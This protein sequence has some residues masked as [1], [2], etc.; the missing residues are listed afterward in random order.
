[1]KRMVQNLV[2]VVV[3]ML[4]LCA[5]LRTEVIL[6]FSPKHIGMFLLGCILLCIPYLRKKTKWSDLKNIFRQNAITAGYL[7]TFM[8]IFVSMM[9]RDTGLEGLLPDLALDLRPLFYGYVCYQ[10]LKNEPE[11]FGSEAKVE[12]GTGANVETGEEEKLGKD[13]GIAESKHGKTLDFSKL[14]RQEKVV[15]ELAGQ[16]LSNREIGEELCISETTVKKHMSNI[17]EKLG[18]SS[19]RELR[20]PARPID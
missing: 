18:I 5:L 4:L 15:A 2:A 7:E 20:K 14:T 8:L 6:L 16:G 17:F 19:R 9:Q 12:I 11:G 10:V 13:Q 3:Y 1:M